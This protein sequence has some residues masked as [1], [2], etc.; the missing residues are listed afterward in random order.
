MNL[1]LLRYPNPSGTPGDLIINRKLFCHTLED[2][3]RPD[4][5]KIQNQT[6]IP[7]KRY[8]I[9]LS[10]SPRFGKILPELLN[11]PNF[12]EIR[13]HGGNT[14]NDTDGCILCANNIAGLDIIQGQ[15]ADELVA[16]L[17]SVHEEIWIE[18]FNTY[19]YY[20]VIS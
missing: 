17:Q 6:A 12:T 9:I 3:V 16:F 7:A 5:I 20:G 2:I 18:I 4:G 11:V 15:S 19:P 10:K 8:Q 1:H 13:M 14:V